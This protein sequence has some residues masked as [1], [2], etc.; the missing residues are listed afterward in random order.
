MFS[1]VKISANTV[2]DSQVIKSGHWIYD[3]MYELGMEAEDT[4]LIDLQP[5]SIGELKFSFKQIDYDKLSETAKRTYDIVYEF[6]FNQKAVFNTKGLKFDFNIKANPEFYYK[7]STDNDYTSPSYIDWTFDYYYKDNVLTV[8]VLFGFGNNLMIETDAF[9]GKNYGASNEYDNFTNIPLQRHTDEFEFTWPRF[10]YGSTGLYFDDWGLNIHIGKEGLNFGKTLMNSIFYSDKFETDSYVQ[11][12]VY[13]QYFQYSL[14]T[15]EIDRT[16]FL[17]MHQI[18]FHPFKKVRVGVIE[19]SMVHGPFELR[20]LNPLM[21]LHSYNGWVDSVD[22]DKKKYYSEDHFCSYFGFTFDLMPVK[23]LRLYGVFSQIEIQLPSER[24]GF[25]GYRPNS[26]GLQS[27]VE[28]NLPV[29]NNNLWKFNLEAAYTSPYLYIKQTPYSSLYRKRMDNLNYLNNTYPGERYV[30]SWIGSPYGPD[31]FALDTKISY[32][33]KQKW[34]F[35]F[36]YKFVIHGEKSFNL[37]NDKNNYVEDKDI[38]IYYPYAKAKYLSETVKDE[39][40]KKQKLTEVYEDANNLWISGNNIYLNQFALEGTYEF[41]KKMS[42]SGKAVYSILL[43]NNKNYEH[44]A[45]G[46]EFDLA[47]K[48][49]LF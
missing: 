21:I 44:I 10:A 5:L 25:G 38:F 18:D 22:E 40:E 34:S 14:S 24:K 2:N 33:K 42:V 3:A 7:N 35:N 17:Y 4:L 37:F 41:T 45:N 36:D 11:A 16:K 49:S 8:P 27:G 39:T 32:E 19:G 30:C 9:V 20:F 13:S 23:N 46:F 1:G 15:V 12:N 48:Y 6:L 31:C 26:V 28:Y 29:R 43:Q 47:I